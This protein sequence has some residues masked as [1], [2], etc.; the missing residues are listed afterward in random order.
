MDP[1]KMLMKY[2]DKLNGGKQAE[3]NRKEFKSQ[4]Y[5]TNFVT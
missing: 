2:F 3:K 5:S 1:Q 4:I